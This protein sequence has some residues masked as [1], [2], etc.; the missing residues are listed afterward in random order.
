MCTTSILGW[1]CIN[2]QLELVC[3][4]IVLLYNEINAA[5]IIRTEIRTTKSMCMRA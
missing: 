4:V 2:I 3:S 5:H 1:I